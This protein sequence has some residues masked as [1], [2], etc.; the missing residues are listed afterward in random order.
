MIVGEECD[1]EADP[2][3]PWTPPIYTGHELDF[4][5]PAVDA[6]AAETPVID[7][8]IISEPVDR[9]KRECNP[10]P[11][12]LF[13]QDENGLDLGE[14]GKLPS[15]KRRVAPKLAARHCQYL[16]DFLD[17][18]P[19]ST[20][21]EVHKALHDEF[22]EVPVSLAT[23]FNCG[24]NM[25]THEKFEKKTIF[26]DEAGFNLHLI[27]EYGWS[28]KGR[29]VNV[30]RPTVRGRNVSVVGAI[31]STGIICMSVTTVDLD[32]D[33]ELVAEDDQ[34]G[35]A[36]NSGRGRGRNAARPPQVSEDGIIG[37]STTGA[38]FRDFI[39]EVL[40]I[41]EAKGMHGY[42]FLMDNAR[43]HKSPL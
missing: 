41:L 35:V 22:P 8:P 6:P 23:V 16:E 29:P 19:L 37:C 4:D 1:E 2:Y 39:C 34:D 31:S 20:L 36:N 12:V 38:Y 18:K 10:V 21:M 26:I 17:E 28:R 15:K 11:D 25:L 7:S 33:E 43:I 24:T 40:E 5:T 3:N 42:T 13:D 9:N 14:T 30:V 27:R 32:A